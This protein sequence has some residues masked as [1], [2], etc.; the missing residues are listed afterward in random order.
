MGRSFRTSKVDNR[1]YLRSI[2]FSGLTTLQELADELNVTREAIRI[3]QIRG[4]RALWQSQVIAKRLGLTPQEFLEYRASNPPLAGSLAR[5]S[6]EVEKDP[7][8]G[9]V[10][11]GPMFIAVD[12][13]S[14]LFRV[15]TE[16]YER[17]NGK[18][19]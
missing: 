10:R 18:G 7:Q 5:A 8:K 15:L 4:L 11:S 19:E 3:R 17:E 1:E 2:Y 14:R 12:R 16:K 13:S 9:V 6:Y